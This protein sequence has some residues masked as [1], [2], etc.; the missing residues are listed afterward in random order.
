MEEHSGFCKVI[1]VLKRI[2]ERGEKH[3]GKRDLG[4]VRFSPVKITARRKPVLISKKNL[5]SFGEKNLWHFISRGFHLKG[6]WAV[7]LYFS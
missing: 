3:M 1:G 6:L 5:R 4:Q 2:Q 7:F